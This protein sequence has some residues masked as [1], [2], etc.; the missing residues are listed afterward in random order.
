ML[1]AIVGS[2]TSAEQTEALRLLNRLILS[3][4]GN[5]AGTELSDLDIG[6]ENDLSSY[7]SGGV[8]DDC[9]LVVIDATSEVDLDPS[10]YEG[11]RI[12]VVDAGAGFATNNLVLN[13]NGRRI[14]GAASVTLSTD[15][16]DRQWLYRSD[17]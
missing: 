2:P 5:G 9:R 16:L 17:T 6:G 7:I 4:V 13:G 3:T 15:D 11:Q 14:E 8:P 12:A 1:T 10:P